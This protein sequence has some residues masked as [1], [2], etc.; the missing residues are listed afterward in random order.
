LCDIQDR[1]DEANQGIKAGNAILGQITKAFRLGW[2]RQLGSELKLLLY[3]SIAI[4]LT[5]YQAVIRYQLPLPSHLERGLIGEPFILEDAIGRQAPVHFQFVTSW[6]AFDAV[7]EIRFRNLQGHR[8]IVEKQYGLQHG[9]TGKEIERSKAWQR[10]FLPGQRVEMSMVFHREEPVSTDRNS[11][12]CPGCHASASNPTDADIRCTNCLLWFRRM[13]VVEDNSSPE[14]VAS[15]KSLIPSSGARSIE[16]SLDSYG[17][18]SASIT[19]DG[20]KVEDV[21]DFKRVRIMSKSKILE[22]VGNPKRV[23]K[24][25]R[26]DYNERGRRY[27]NRNSGLDGF[28]TYRRRK[29]RGCNAWMSSS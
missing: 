26:D 25:N 16:K 15:Q 7:L 28:S 11:V 27:D 4:N 3:R 10:A 2:L 13:T 8:K 29:E 17:K 9:A 5:T 22:R 19:L 12:T 6:D 18:T 21:R 24:S 20:D 14:K 23:G 1:I